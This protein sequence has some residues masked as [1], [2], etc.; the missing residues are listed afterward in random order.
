MIK[1]SNTSNLE[2]SE[3]LNKYLI[4][5]NTDDD[6]DLLID[7]TFRI[8]LRI[9]KDRRVIRFFSFISEDTLK[10]I[11]DENFNSFLDFING[12]SYSVKYSKMGLDLVRSPLLCEY[13]I[14]NEGSVDDSFIVKTI[15]MIEKEISQALNTL[16]HFE[17]MITEHRKNV[18]T[19]ESSKEV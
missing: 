18:T 9:Q 3:M 7:G 14:S 5:S 16:S 10:D 2:I 15:Q 13:C 8:Y 12:A 1:L 4:G 19:M 6:G 17:L 11:T